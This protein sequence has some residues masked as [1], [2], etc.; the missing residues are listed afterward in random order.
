MPGAGNRGFKIL[1][2]AFPPNLLYNA[3]GDRYLDAK[4]KVSFPVLTWPGL[5]EPAQSLHLR[6]VP[7]GQ[8][9]LFYHILDLYVQGYP[10]LFLDSR[11]GR[12]ALERAEDER[13]VFRHPVEACPPETEFM[14]QQGGVFFFFCLHTK[15]I[16]FVA[17]QI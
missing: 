7:Q 14:M 1:K 16:R 3:S 5:E 12:R 8:H 17:L 13:V 9:F 11:T 2:A 6:F 10:F 15:S 4:E